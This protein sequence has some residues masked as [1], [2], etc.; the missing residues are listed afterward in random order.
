MVENILVAQELV[1]HY[2]KDKLP[3]RC[4]VKL[5]LMK[6]F[7]SVQWSYLFNAFK[8][9]GFPNKFI[10][11]IE[12]CI[13]SPTFSISL[14]GCLEGYFH[15]RK[16]IRQ[17]DPLSPYL[18]VIC[19]KALARMLNKGATTG[20]LPFHPKCKKVGL[21]H[22]CF[23]D[24]LLIFTDGSLKGMQTIDSILKQFYQVTGL[25]VN[26]QNSELFV[27]DCKTQ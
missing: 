1:K 22:L 4:A 13:T 27:V 19:M 15:G 14:N 11:W 5:N 26:C 24:D 8:A 12:V 9:L 3:S 10:R 17:G 21:T 20:A 23:T 7:D 25:K 6:A 16:G 2:H 18:F